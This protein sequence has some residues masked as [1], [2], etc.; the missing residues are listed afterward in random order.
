VS[1]KGFTLLRPKALSPFFLLHL[2]PP[3]VLATGLELP[4]STA[5]PALSSDSRTV[6]RL[7]Y[8]V[9]L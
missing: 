9:V 4:R 8:P 1:G 3:Y 7:D 6:W 2:Y 5:L